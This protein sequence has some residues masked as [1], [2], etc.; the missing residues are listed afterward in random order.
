MPSILSVLGRHLLY[1][2]TMCKTPIGD[3][4]VVFRVHCLHSFHLGPL[5]FSVHS[6]FLQLLV[7]N[8]IHNTR[9][10]FDALTLFL[11]MPVHALFLCVC[12]LCVWCMDEI[13]DP[14]CLAS[15]YRIVR[16]RLKLL[17]RGFNSQGAH[18]ALW[19]DE[20]V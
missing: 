9:G 13:L 4:I 7:N 5:F 20:L 19:L 15:W 12:V 1:F 14:M 17:C 10:V 8:I 2:A 11:Y 6:T 3:F 16:W 18:E